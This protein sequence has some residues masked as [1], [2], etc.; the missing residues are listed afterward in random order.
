MRGGG[1]VNVLRTPRL[2]TKPTPKANGRMDDHRNK[3]FPRG[4]TG[5]Q[6]WRVCVYSGS[7]GYV[8]VWQCVTCQTQY[9]VGLAGYVS[10]IY[11]QTSASSS[12]SS[13][14]GVDKLTLHRRGQKVDCVEVSN[15]S[16]LNWLVYTLYQLSREERNEHWQ[17]FKW[18][19]YNKL[20]SAHLFTETNCRS[21]GWKWYTCWYFRRT[22]NNLS[23]PPTAQRGRANK[24]LTEDKVWEVSSYNRLWQTRSGPSLQVMIEPTTVLTR[25]SDRST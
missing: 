7:L 15:D 4:L 20:R 12:G 13:G 9:W 10:P 19:V 8:S 5:V 2:S 16:L 22:I 3:H 23:E 24:I 21:S 14:G 11:Q 1:L 18:I 6:K 17:I 25:G